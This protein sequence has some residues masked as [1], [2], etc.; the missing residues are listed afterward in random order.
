[1][2]ESLVFEDIFG[3]KVHFN[4]GELCISISVN[5]SKVVFM[6]K[7]QIQELKNWLEDNYPI[8]KEY[9]HIPF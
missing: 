6:N 8:T 1:M 7:T 5:E 4:A 2:K 9:K 3:D